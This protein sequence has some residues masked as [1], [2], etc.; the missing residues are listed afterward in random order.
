VLRAA[1]IAPATV[2]AHLERWAKKVNS[3]QILFLLVAVV[4]ILASVTKR[5]LVIRDNE[6]KEPSSTRKKFLASQL[7]AGGLIVAGLGLVALI[8]YVFYFEP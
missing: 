5:F 2:V 7:V 6:P 8:A 4:A 3:L 1:R